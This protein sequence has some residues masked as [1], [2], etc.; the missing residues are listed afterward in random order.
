MKRLLL[1]II[2]C[3][4]TGAFAAAQ[5]GESA[6]HKPFSVAGGIEL[7]QNDRVSILPELFVMSDYELSRYFGFG[8]R[9]GLT[10]ASNKPS[11]RL[12]SVM[13]GVLYGRFYVYDFGW[14]RPFIQ[15][16]V[17]VSVNREQEYEVYDALGEV[18]FGA[19]AHLK[20][21]FIESSFRAGYPFRV[22]FGLAVG[23]SFLP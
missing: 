23:H 9:G 22:A 16:G 11:D 3:A 19:R 1:F 20:G 2:V 5:T 14:I 21:W 10:F 18:N 6:I 7:T 13:E 12:V 4:C 17:G 15:T 8:I